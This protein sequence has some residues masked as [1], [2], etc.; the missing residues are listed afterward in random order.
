MLYCADAYFTSFVLL[1]WNYL[2]W[3][4][5]YNSLIYVVHEYEYWKAKFCIGTPLPPII[6][7]MCD[8]CHVMQANNIM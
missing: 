1:L 6:K 2:S 7:K 8:T 5:D 3:L 4:C